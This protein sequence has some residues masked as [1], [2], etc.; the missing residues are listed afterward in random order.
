MVT[1]VPVSWQTRA[2]LPKRVATGRDLLTALTVRSTGVLDLATTQV[3][4][5]AA[6][7]VRLVGSQVAK[8]GFA[9]AS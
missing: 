2:R 7:A 6:R 5:I 4:A 1:K 3:P 8:A 9:S